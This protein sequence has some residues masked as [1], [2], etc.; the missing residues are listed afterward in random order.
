MMGRILTST[1][2]ALLVLVVAGISLVLLY[3]KGRTVE[4][5]VG[6]GLLVVAAFLIYRG[7]KTEHIDE[8]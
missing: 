4:A 1:A 5:A 8:G 2:F 3:F 6:T 7:A